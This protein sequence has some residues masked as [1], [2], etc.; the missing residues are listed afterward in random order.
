MSERTPLSGREYSA[1]QTLFAMVSG[2]SDECLDILRKRCEAAGCWEQMQ[3]VERLA[4]ESLHAIL[5][6]VPENKLRHIQKDLGNIRLHIRI[7]PPGLRTKTEGFNYTPTDTLNELL[8]HLCQTECSMCDKTA[9]ES[10]HCPYRKWIEDALPHDVGGEDREHC[11][12][13]DLVLGLEA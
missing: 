8:N 11:K 3:E 6:T 2:F 1:I 5:R 10:R 13:S 12:F 9:V 7:E 4:N